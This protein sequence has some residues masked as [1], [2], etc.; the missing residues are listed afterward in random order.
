MGHRRAGRAAPLT[1][2]SPSRDELFPADL[3][4]MLEENRHRVLEQTDFSSRPPLFFFQTLNGASQ[5]GSLH[6]MGPTGKTGGLLCTSLVTSISKPLPNRVAGSRESSGAR[7]HTRPIPDIALSL[8]ASPPSHANIIL[9]NITPRADEA[10]QSSLL[11]EGPRV[12]PSSCYKGENFI[13]F[14]T[15][16]PFFNFPSGAKSLPSLGDARALT[17]MLWLPLAATGVITT[18]PEA[19]GCHFCFHGNKY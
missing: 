8:L 19:P 18:L 5:V 2:T 7:H 15:A 11:P 17:S 13:H 12:S 4:R 6:R 9:Q 10:G 1:A 14:T 3:H 16:F